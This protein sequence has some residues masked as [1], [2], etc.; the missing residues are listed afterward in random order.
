MTVTEPLP[1]ERFDPLITAAAESVGLAAREDYLEL[2][3]Q[4]AWLSTDRSGAR[5]GDIRTELEL[6]MVSVLLEDMVEREVLSRSA[7]GDYR[8]NVR[9]FER[10]LRVNRPARIGME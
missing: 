9:L 2:L 4:I 8:I 3:S 10:W 7:R 6:S 5:S 1:I